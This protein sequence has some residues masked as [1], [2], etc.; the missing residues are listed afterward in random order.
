M[1]NVDVLIGFFLGILFGIAFVFAWIKRKIKAG[2]KP[3]I[4]ESTGYLEWYND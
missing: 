4:D 1:I 3:F 2:A